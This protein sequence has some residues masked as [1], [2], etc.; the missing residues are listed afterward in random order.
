MGDQGRPGSEGERDRGRGGRG[1]AFPDP[2]GVGLGNKEKNPIFVN[3]SSVN[4]FKCL[5]TNGEGILNKRSELANILVNEDPDIVLISEVLPNNLRE[6][7]QPS[8]LCFADYDFYSNCFSENVHLGTAIYVKSKLR[9]QQVFLE[10][11]HE[12]ARECVW[13]EITLAA[14]DKLLV[15]CVY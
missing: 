6:L 5:C 12:N 11:N 1:A 10:K 3:T 4:S 7:V 8:E 15:G 13:V 9:A 14:T 2:G